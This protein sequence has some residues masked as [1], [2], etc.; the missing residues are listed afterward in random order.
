[1]E[2]NFSLKVEDLAKRITDK[3]KIILIN[4]PHNPTGA[5]IGKEDLEKKLQN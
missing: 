1:M 3:T 5:I 2:N 4:T